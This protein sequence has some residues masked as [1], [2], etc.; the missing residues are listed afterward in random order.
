M[1]RILVIV[2][3]GLGVLGL[4]LWK[5]AASN[6]SI[7]VT[8]GPLL[9]PQGDPCN[10]EVSF[11]TVRNTSPFPVLTSDWRLEDSIGV[12]TFP[13]R[14]VA[15]GQTVTVWSGTGTS[16]AANLYAGRAAVAWNTQRLQL[17]S[18]LFSYMSAREC[19]LK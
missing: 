6:A 5:L 16:D 3:I 7:E 9:G 4:I 12:Y 1:R 2:L 8:Q 15:P 10:F 11:I 19:A 18:L 17:T 13:N 14:W